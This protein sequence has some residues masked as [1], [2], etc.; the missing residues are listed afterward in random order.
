M[1]FKYT[2]FASAL[3]ATG[4]LSLPYAAN[5]NDSTELEE[6][7]SLVQ[8]LS[9]QV[10][11]LARKG[12]IN[13]EAVAAAKK[14]APVVKASS[15]GFSFGSADGKNEIKFRG[16]LQADHRHFSDGANDVRNRSNTRAGS[17]DEN[18]FHDAE[19]TSLLRRVRPTI[20][21]KVAGKY[22]FRF[23]PEFG[24]GSASAVD[25]YVE[26]NLN[27]AFKIRAGKQKSIVGLER[28]QGGGDIKFRGCPR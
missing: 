21:G 7:R 20:E 23:T 4:L 17:L 11:V 27:P 15:S 22:G 9:Q 1:Q 10:K 25:A 2:K 5:A 16:L 28:L 24:G 12:E 14:E 3:L 26:A 13:E 6:L 8:E 19:D 18:G